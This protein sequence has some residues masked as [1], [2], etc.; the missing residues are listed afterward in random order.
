MPYFSQ[1]QKKAI[2][3]KVAAL[4]KE[5]G[6]KGSLSVRH[7]SE[8]SLTISQGS[9]D[10]FGNSKR[11]EQHHMQINHHWIS[12]HFS[13][14]VEEFLLKALNLLNTGNYDRSDAQVDYFDCGHYISIHIGKWNKPYVLT[15]PK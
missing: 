5:Y 1:D 11:S 13:G 12:E 15:A 6:V 4:C 9:L 7:N 8:V 10:F 2:A 14:K 3:P